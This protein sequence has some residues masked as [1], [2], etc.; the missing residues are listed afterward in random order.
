VDPSFENVFRCSG[1][2]IKGNGISASEDAEKMRGVLK[3]AR[4]NFGR[5]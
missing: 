4:T 2:S 3:G 1:I 5:S